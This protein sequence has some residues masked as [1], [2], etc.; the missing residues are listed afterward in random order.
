MSLFKH[1]SFAVALFGA[2]AFS[3]VVIQGCSSDEQNTP[4]AGGSGGSHAGSGGKPSSAGSAGKPVSEGGAAGEEQPGS[5]GA[6]GESEPGMAGAGGE[7][8]A[9]PVDC[10]LS[11]DNRSL[12]VLTDNGGVLPD[13]P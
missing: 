12:Q 1:N 9:A 8:G 5:G 10:D 4:A 7:A 11:F 6:A 13:L 3:L 2:L